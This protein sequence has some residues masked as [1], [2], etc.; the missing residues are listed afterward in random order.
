MT[1]S[2]QACQ[3]RGGRGGGGSSLR[4]EEERVSSQSYRKSKRLNEIW[5]K[6]SYLP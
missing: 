4:E 2:T 5:G 1:N 3:E 6:V